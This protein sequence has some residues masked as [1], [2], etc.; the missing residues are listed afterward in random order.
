MVEHL[1]S[2]TLGFV[3]QKEKKRWGVVGMSTIPSLRN[4]K[5]KVEFYS[6]SLS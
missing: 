6:S 2:E 4:E 1:P 5:M 3:V